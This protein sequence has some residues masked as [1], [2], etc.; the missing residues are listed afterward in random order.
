M[1]DLVI[2]RVNTLAGDQPSHLSFTDRQ[3]R[4]IGDSDDLATAGSEAAAAIP[5]EDTDMNWGK[6]IEGTDLVETPG[7]DHVELPGV[8]TEPES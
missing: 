5:L 8:A 1:P 6:E 7:V 3:G 4:L 2:D